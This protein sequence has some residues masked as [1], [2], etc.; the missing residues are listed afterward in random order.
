MKADQKNKIKILRIQFGQSFC[1]IEVQI[2]G[3]Y[4]SSAAGLAS[5]EEKNLV[6]N[7]SPSA[8]FNFNTVILDMCF[9]YG[10]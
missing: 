9:L 1:N 6:E 8:Y 7:P 2:C 4:L 10:Q 3:S 5:C